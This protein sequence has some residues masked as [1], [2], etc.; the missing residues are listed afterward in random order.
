M[1]SRW[2]W[3]SRVDVPV[4]GAPRTYRY[5]MN[6]G[7]VDAQ[8]LEPLPELSPDELEELKDHVSD[9]DYLERLLPPENFEFQGF[10]VVR[11][12]DVTEPQLISAIERDLIDQR[13]ILTPDGFNALQ[14]KLRILFQIP[15]LLAGVVALLEGNVYMLSKGVDVDMQCVFTDAF[16]APVS[17][18]YGTIYERALQSDA[19]IRV[20]DTD[21]EETLDIVRPLM[22]QSGVRCKLIA[23]L[24][25]QDECIGVLEIGTTRPG[26]LTSVDAMRLGC[27]QPVFAMAVKRALSDMDNQ[28]QAVIKQTCT[29]IHPSVEWRFRRAAFR[30]LKQ[31]RSQGEA[32]M[33]P[34]VFPEVYPLYGACDIRGSSD[35]RNQAIG[36]D[37]RKHLAL[38]REILSLADAARPQPFLRELT[39]RIERLDRRVSEGLGSGD[40]NLVVNFLANEVASTFDHLKMLGP[41]VVRAIDAYNKAVDPNL[42]T[43]Y[44]QR[45]LFEH[46][47][48]LLNDRLLAYLD[49]E[50][51]EQQ[52]SF[53]HYFERHRSDGVDYIIYLG[54]SLMEKGDFSPL[55]LKNL[56]LWQ[57]MVA[58]GMAWHASQAGPD[59]PVPLE[60][61][62][63]ILV[64]NAP[65]AISFR[66]D[67]RRFDVDGA[68][69]VRYE[70]IKS[71]LDKATVKDT[72]E[73]L[74]Q[75][76]KIALVYTQTAEAI[77]IRHHVEFLQDE[78]FLKP[79]LER[80]ELDDLPG[81]QGLRAMRVGIN[82][83]NHEFAQRTPRSICG[84]NRS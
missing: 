18:F 46:S 64:Q 48:S 24:Y 81:V 82:L 68:Y 84:L 83:D 34:I 75:P 20:A 1:A 41:K 59:L 38:A 27:L 32:Q 12:V 17:E 37:L 66:F 57:I 62:Q 53:P 55:V 79:E 43:V 15:D 2:N 47:V 61:A 4:S 11:A 60:V 50:E 8:A 36:I 3:I 22:E 13:S 45:R 42:G 69:N 73:R 40:E 23:P 77:E 74:T 78:G 54:S 19:V 29:A 76:G 6:F 70:I 80:L 26:E 35:A 33:E 52:S 44:E 56:R 30:Y 31:M 58:C 49:Q 10:T 65:L 63:L 16:Q 72:G 7:F 51:A 14:D 21:K 28:V 25:Y 39:T 71:R 5:N 67:E 9:L